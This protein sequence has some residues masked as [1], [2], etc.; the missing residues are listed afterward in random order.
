MWLLYTTLAVGIVEKFTYVANRGTQ[1]TSS[2]PLFSMGVETWQPVNFLMQ[3]TDASK[4]L[5]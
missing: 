5:G 1:I 4:M 2:L 3:T